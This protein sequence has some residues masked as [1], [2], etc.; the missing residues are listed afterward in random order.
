MRFL[1][2]LVFL[3][4]CKISS[5]AVHRTKGKKCPVPGRV[6]NM[7]L[8]G[9]SVLS[10]AYIPPGTFIR[11]SDAGDQGHKADESPRTRV[12]ITRGFWLGTTEVTIAQWQ[13]VTGMNVRQKATRLLNDTVRYDF[14][15][16]KEKLRDFM[17]F[18]STDPDSILANENRQ[19]PMY[20][21]SWNEA[22]AFCAR[23]NTLEKAAGRLP[24]GYIYT[25][26]T[27]AQWE[28]A[29]RAG[30][31]QGT[32]L[33]EN[34]GKFTRVA[35]TGTI[36]WYHENSSAGYTG[37][38]FG[39]P[40]DGPRLSGQLLPNKWGMKDM[41]GNIWEWCLDWYGPYEGGNLTDPSGPVS[42]SYRV[43]KGGSFGS[44]VNDERAANRAQN[45]PNEQ[46]AYRGF[47]L[48]LTPVRKK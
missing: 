20:F 5:G 41:L 21:V 3:C 44:G 35:L 7:P 26:P 34:K 45:P 36:A 42:G 30:S 1:F 47:R 4:L 2:V 16:R 9:R 25:L 14:N 37:R 23:L 22:I 11:G 48:A 32:Y 6:W 46:S 39:N 40:P 10:M 33:T 17:N 15:G 8:S 13:A 28:Y 31:G 12:T 29:C 38:G 27:E 24:A 18:H 43:N 19:L